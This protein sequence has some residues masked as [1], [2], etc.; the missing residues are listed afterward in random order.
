[1]F[2]FKELES[3]LATSVCLISLTQGGDFLEKKKKGI[4]HFTLKKSLI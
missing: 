1:M 4:N 3:E 2:L